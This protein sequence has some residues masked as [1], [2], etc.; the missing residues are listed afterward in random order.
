VK[1]LFLDVDGV[2]NSAEWFAKQPAMSP[3]M[4]LFL[5]AVDPKPVRRI[6]NVLSATGAVIVLS[7]T[8][9]LV[10]EYVQVL[11]AAGLPIH[12]VTPRIPDVPRWQE[13][14]SWLRCRDAAPVQF[15][16]LDDDPDAG[17][18]PMLAPYFVRTHWKYGMYG[19][20]ERQLMEILK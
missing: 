13:I 17:D 7:S 9:R 1:V 3:K 14:L 18:H 10:P 5:C 6:Q 19:K 20:H 16:I 2:L 8:W 15:A 4:P 12:D 11:R